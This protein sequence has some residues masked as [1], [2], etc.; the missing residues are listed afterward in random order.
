[1]IS[2]YQAAPQ[3]P[4]KTAPGYASDYNVFLEGAKKSFFG[5]KNS[6]V[7]PYVT[8]LTIKDHPRGA[9]ITFSMNDTPFRVK[10][11]RVNAELVGVFPTVGQNIE[12][13]YGHPIKVNTDINSRKLTQ[14]IVG[15]LKDLK[16]GVNT[17]VWPVKKH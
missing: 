7:D 4:P 8:G 1:L 12:D 6:V 17:I 15:P 9:T 11:P 13:R 3:V 2:A 16:Q 10:V 5:D 14:P